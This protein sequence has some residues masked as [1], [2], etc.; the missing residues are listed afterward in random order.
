MKAGIS[1][2]ATSPPNTLGSWQMGWWVVNRG[3]ET[4]VL[5]MLLII[6]SSTNYRTSNYQILHNNEEWGLRR[7]S[8]PQCSFLGHLVTWVVQWQLG[9]PLSPGSSS[10]HQIIM[11][12]VSGSKEEYSRGSRRARALICFFLFHLLIIKIII[13]IYSSFF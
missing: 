13:L 11:E 9:R 2:M 1:P 8:G 12:T 3:L 10:T 6:F 5:G 4:R 7:V